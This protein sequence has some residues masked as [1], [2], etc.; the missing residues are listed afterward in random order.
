VRIIVIRISKSYSQAVFIGGGLTHA[1]DLLKAR[2]NS[3]GLVMDQHSPDIAIADFSGL[4]CRW[5]DIQSVHG[6][7]V[8]LLVLVLDNDATANW[9]YK[10]V[11]EH[12]RLIYGDDQ[13][14]H[15][16]AAESLNLS[17]DRQKLMS[18]TKVRR[19]DSS[20]WSTQWYLIKTR[21]QNCLGW[22]LM[23][24]N[25]Q[26]GEVHWG[27]YKRDV[28][29]ATDHRKFDDMLRMVIS[30]TIEQRQRL[31]EILE[32]Y[33]QAGKLVY[34]MHVSDRALLTC[35]VFEHNDRHVHFVDGADGGYAL[36]AKAM[37]QQLSKLD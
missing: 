30:G 25:L 16:I 9:L 17:F 15:P 22:L 29:A 20:W 33:Y 31:T 18:E 10:D 5:Q 37:K 14:L 4:E 26:V 6:E 21:L 34:G 23:K 7:T 36:A 35:L 27:E 12:I 1:T 3:T 19:H 28:A 8:S 32:Q 13:D 11:I 2:C 24:L